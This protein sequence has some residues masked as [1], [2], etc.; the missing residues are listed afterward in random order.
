MIRLA[1]LSDAD[2]LLAIYRFYVMETAVTFDDVP[3]SLDAFRDKIAAIQSFYPYL[4]YEEDGEI[5]GYAY[6]TA[7]HSRPA[8]AWSAEVAIYLA[9]LARGKGIG[10]ALYQQLETYLKEMGVLNLNACIA[11]TSVE[12]QYLTNASQAFHASCGYQLVGRFHQSGYKFQRWYDMIWMEKLI[13]QHDTTVA[14]VTSIQEILGISQQIS[15][16]HE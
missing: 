16:P 14:P 5:L 13:G 3:P 15:N 1:T 10:K 12:D 6:A 9:P 11:S 4:V 2:S 8:Y 7:F